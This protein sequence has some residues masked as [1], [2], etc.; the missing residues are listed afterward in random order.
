MM[1]QTSKRE[2]LAAIRPRYTLGNRT[3]KQL[4]LDELGSFAHFLGCPGQLGRDDASGML[5]E[6]RKGVGDVSAAPI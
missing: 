6:Q 5:A 3:E 2:L 4:V 1:S